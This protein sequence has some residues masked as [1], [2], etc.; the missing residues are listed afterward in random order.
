MKKWDFS[1]VENY[2]E[3]KKGYAVEKIAGM[4]E[5]Y[6]RFLSLVI[7]EQTP[8]PISYEVDPFWHVHVLH[9]MNYIPFSQEVAGGFLHHNPVATE[10]ERLA[11]Q[12]EYDG[13]IALYKKHYGEPDPAFWGGSDMVCICCCPGSISPLPQ[14]MAA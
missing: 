13:F 8:A 2:L 9:T 12:D 5:E 11:L 4:K 1:V 14:G 6:M 7:G 3:R 10:E